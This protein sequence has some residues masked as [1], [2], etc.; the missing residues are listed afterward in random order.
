[1]LA[2]ES[3]RRKHIH[4]EVLNETNASLEALHLVG[5]GGNRGAADS[6]GR[7]TFDHFSREHKAGGGSGAIGLLSCA[8]FE[9]GCGHGEG[10]GLVT[11]EH[12]WCWIRGGIVLAE[13]SAMGRRVQHDSEVP[14]LRRYRLSTKE[15]LI[16]MPVHS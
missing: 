11:F 9:G 7:Q 4:T 5:R 2:N 13:E 6:I 12:R 1:M 15:T 3:T 14:V 8:A 10:Q 16:V